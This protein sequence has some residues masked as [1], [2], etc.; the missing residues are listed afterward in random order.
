MRI[1]RFTGPLVAAALL[2]A[3]VSAQA[4][5]VVLVDTAA[6]E[7]RNGAYAGFYTLSID[8]TTLPGMCDDFSTHINV[9]DSWMATVNTYADIMGGAGK[10]GPTVKYN[11]AGWL[12][13][14]ATSASA[15]DQASID[16]AIWKIM[17]PS[18]AP[19]PSTLAGQN[20]LA[21]AT[22]GSHDTFDFTNIMEVVT[23]IPPSASQEFLIGPMASV[24]V[25]AAAWLFASGL[26]GLAGVARRRAAR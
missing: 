18:G 24:P 17:D 13:S 26:A 9:G 20:Y 10:F 19:T 6:S 23:A 8:A 7:V 14:L 4:S 5:S 11:Q 12:F 2:C 21:M 15:S 25:P 22:G 1:H 3:G 16:E